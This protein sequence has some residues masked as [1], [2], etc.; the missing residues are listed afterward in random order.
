LKG[1]ST[2]ADAAKAVK[3]DHSE[4]SA[5]NPLFEVGIAAPASLGLMLRSRAKRGVPI[6]GYL[7]LGDAAHRASRTRVNALPQDAEEKG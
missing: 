7:N 2:L 5:S 4:G 3:K 1:R 6:M